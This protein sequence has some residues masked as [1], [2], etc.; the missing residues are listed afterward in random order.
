MRS[1]RYSSATCGRTTR[2]TSKSGP[3]AVRSGYAALTP[4]EYDWA[5]GTLD[6]HKLFFWFD[7][8]GTGGEAGGYK[9]RQGMTKTHEV[10]LG[11]DGSSPPLDRPLLTVAPPAGPQTRAP[12]AS[13]PWPTPAR[14]GS[15]V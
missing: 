10:W 13:S 4:N 15:R 12:S 5:K 11:L 8:Q 6:E 2:K 7:A 9:L 1:G 3:A 14:G